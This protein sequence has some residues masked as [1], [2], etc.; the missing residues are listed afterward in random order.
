MMQF[1]VS[2]FGIRQLE[3]FCNC[4]QCCCRAHLMLIVLY[5]GTGRYL[6]LLARPPLRLS[7]CQ[8]Q[9]LD[10]ESFLQFASYVDAVTISNDKWI[11]ATLRSG[12]TALLSPFI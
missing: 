2:R 10:S 12:K 11:Q 1:V 5:P 7:V 3:E 8:F 6:R 4:G 9:S